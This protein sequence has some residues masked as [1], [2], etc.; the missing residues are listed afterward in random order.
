MNRK[1]VILDANVVIKLHELGIWNQV[2]QKCDVYLAET[3]LKSEVQYYCD[4]QGNQHTI[5]P[6]LLAQQVHKVFH[7]TPTDLQRFL[8]S[9]TPLYR[10]ELDPGEL[11]SLC[12]LLGAKNV[13]P[14]LLICS[15]DGIVFRVL[16]CCN[17]P[18]NGISLEELLKS[19][20]LQK[21]LERQYTEPFRK[22][23]TRMGSQDG[24]QGRSRK[25]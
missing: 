1:A 3:V 19:L 18:Q 17:R 16:G 9:F 2:C 7:V 21:K 23:W 4:A 15:A 25:S 22:H 11:E 13:S 20:G 24:I 8:S 12:W 5:D 10:G 6:D 14:G